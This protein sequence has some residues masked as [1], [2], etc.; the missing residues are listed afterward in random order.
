MTA[1]RWITIL[2]ALLLLSLA[3]NLFIGGVI[4]GRGVGGVGEGGFRVG[5]ERIMRAL[6]DSDR[7]AMQAVLDRRRDELQQRFIDFR[8]ARRAAGELLR[9]DAFDAAAFAAAEQDAREKSF[10]LQNAVRDLVMEAVP[11]LSPEGRAALAKAPW[12]G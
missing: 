8:A 10:A 3:V 2:G 4:L 12:R 11:R 5:I 7:E 6:P 9:A 1:R